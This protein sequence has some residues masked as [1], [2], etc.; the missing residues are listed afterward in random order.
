MKLTHCYVIYYALNCYLTSYYNIII[1]S[2][3]C[4][5]CLLIHKDNFEYNKLEIGTVLN[6]NT[7][8]A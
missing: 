1:S 7:Y 2:M 8:L 6:S 5:A 4:P 3:P